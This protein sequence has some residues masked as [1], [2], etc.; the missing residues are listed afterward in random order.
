MSE[1]NGNYI[2]FS[3]TD[4]GYLDVVRS[5]EGAEAR[6]IYYTYDENATALDEKEFA[7]TANTE[8]VGLLAQVEMPYADA[9]ENHCKEITRLCRAIGMSLTPLHSTR[10]LYKLPYE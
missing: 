6:F 8:L 9:Q 5:S 7:K 1:P 2:E 10:G 4:S 3:Y